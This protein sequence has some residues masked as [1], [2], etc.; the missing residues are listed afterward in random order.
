MI[1]SGREDASDSRTK[2]CGQP[3]LAVAETDRGDRA[4]G[5]SQ[6]WRERGEQRRFAGA[7]WADDFA[8]PICRREF[9]DELCDAFAGSELKLDRAG[10]RPAGGERIAV[11]RGQRLASDICLAHDSTGAAGTSPKRNAASRK[12]SGPCCG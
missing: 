5:G 12:T 3:A 9:G 2:F 8:A 4:T 1:K 10:P 7:V 6:V 11:P